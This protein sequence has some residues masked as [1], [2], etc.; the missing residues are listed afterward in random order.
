M[1]HYQAWRSGKVNRMHTMP[2]LHRENI[3]EHT[4]GVLLAVV[5]YYPQATA[6]F[7]RAVIMHDA[8][9]IAT[10][11]IPGHVK[12]SNPELGR[13]VEMMERNYVGKLAQISELSIT[14]F[15]LLEIFDRLD[16]CVS[17]VHEMRMGNLNSARY[18]KRSY[19]KAESIYESMRL[20]DKDVGVDSLSE[21]AA[22]ASAFLEEVTTL[23]NIYLTHVSEEEYDLS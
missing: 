3:A 9:E 5:R 13:R 19:E 11:D 10:G 16:F 4:W 15:W 6:D 22:A 20:A 18:F 14:E 12:W 1:D 17:C 8:G 23:K 21:M 7:L 2:Q